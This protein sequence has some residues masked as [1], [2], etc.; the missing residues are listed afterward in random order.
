[1][2]YLTIVPLK[3]TDLRYMHLSIGT[4]KKIVHLFMHQSTKTFTCPLAYALLHWYLHQSTRSCTSSQLMHY[5]NC[6]CTSPAVQALVHQFM[7]SPPV[8]AIVHQ[9]MHKSTRACITPPVKC[10][11]PP[12]LH[13]ALH[14]SPSRHAP[15]RRLCQVHQ[16]LRYSTNSCTSPPVPYPMYYSSHIT[17]H[18][19]AHQFMHQFTSSCTSPQLRIKQQFMHQSSV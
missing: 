14:G 18:A 11:T 15:V 12:I 10:I 6:S 17:E 2:I 3:K 19:L 1:M 5:P 7:N 8:Y 16:F 9:I 13:V 4:C